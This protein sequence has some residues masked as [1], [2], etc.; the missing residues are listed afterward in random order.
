MLCRTCLEDKS[1]DN[2]QINTYGVIRK[3]CNYCFNIKMKNK[4]KEIKSLLKKNVKNIV[5]GKTYNIK[6][7]TKSKGAREFK[8]MAIQIFN[9]F[10]LFQS[11]KGYKECFNDI[12][13][14]KKYYI[15]EVV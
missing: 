2:F 9:D 7:V 3:E 5:K 12:D 15:Q 14:K 8:G 11:D 13:I 6:P 4:K 1:I 10:T